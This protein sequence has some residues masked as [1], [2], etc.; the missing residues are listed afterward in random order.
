MPYTGYDFS[1][2]SPTDSKTYSFDFSI[3]LASGDGIVGATLV[4]LPVVGADPNP[5]GHLIGNPNINGLVVSQTIANLLT[6]VSYC[7]VCAI[8]TISGQ[9]ISVSAGLSCVNDC[10]GYLN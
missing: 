10:V 1:P 5:E 6:G 7:V 4:L 8:T 9:T 3:A 2:A